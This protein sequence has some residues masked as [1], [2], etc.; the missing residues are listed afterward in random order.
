M[1][2]A[3]YSLYNV[4]LLASP[5]VREQYARAA[6]G[7][8]PAVKVNDALFSLHAAAI[9]LFTLLQIAWYERGDQRF[10]WPAKL[11]ATSI[12]V[13]AGVGALLAGT[14]SIKWVSWL[15]YLNALALVKLGITLFKYMPQLWLNYSR[16]STEGW[17][18]DNIILD[19]TGGAL[20]LSQLVLDAACASDWSKIS[21]DPV[22][23]G[24]G[25]VSMLFDVLFMMQ[26]FIWYR[27][28]ATPYPPLLPAS[29][30]PPETFSTPPRPQ[31]Q[32]A[33]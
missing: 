15:Q 18:I 9:S 5:Y 23:F 30:H 14:V 32:R 1:G 25:L 20:S 3:C 24:L 4:A 31:A 21:G 13:A 7:G 17:N 2:Y 6:G 28:I 29:M 27:P 12:A 33:T 8:S 10:S 26:H 16:R 19:F 11:A 22:K